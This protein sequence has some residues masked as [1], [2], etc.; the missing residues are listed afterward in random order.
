MPLF[1]RFIIIIFIIRSSTQWR[2]EKCFI[3]LF[4]LQCSYAIC[5]KHPEDNRKSVEREAETYKALGDRE[6]NCYYEGKTLQ[7]VIL[8]KKYSRDDVIH[9]MFWPALVIAICGIIFLRL[10]MKRRNMKWCWEEVRG[11]AEGCDDVKNS[12]KPLIE[13]SNKPLVECHLNNDNK[14]VDCKLV[15]CKAGTTQYMSS[16]LSCLDRINKDVVNAKTSSR[17][18]LTNGRIICSSSVDALKNKQV[19][20]SEIDLKQVIARVNQGSK[21]ALPTDIKIK[22]DSP[23]STGSRVTGMETPV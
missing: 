22:I 16:S 14:R 6:F 3:F 1:H 13:H 4:L 20:Q 17:P 23:S 7:D 12:S 2:L 8:E 18:S 21:P 15:K 11:V 10:E 19:S 5:L 9:G